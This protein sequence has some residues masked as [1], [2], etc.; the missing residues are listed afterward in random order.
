VGPGA[1]YINPSILLEAP[2]GINW[3]T[4]PS[5]RPTPDQQYA[6]QYNIC[7]RATGM[8]DAYCNQPLRATIDTEEFTGPGDFR[9]QNQP[10]G[11]TRILCSRGPVVS[12]ISGQVS[13]AASFPRSWSPIA[14]D[15]FE[16]EVP[17]IGV[18]G[19]T[20]PGDSAAGGQAVLLAPGWVN[21]AFG[22][23]SSRIQ[24]T[25]QSGWPHGSLTLAATA[26]SSSLAVDDITGWLG[27]VGTVFGGAQQEAVQVTAVTPAVTGAISGPGTLTLAAALSFNHQIGDIVSALPSAVQQA[28]ILYATAQALVRGA[29][30]TAVQSLGGGTNS[31]GPLGATDLEVAAGKLVHAY[32]RRI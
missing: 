15:Q 25:Y 3:G 27:A 11:V 8:I 9:V 26:G 18:Y 20:A 30:S 31:G 29:T 6:A 4:L 1:P 5:L 2:T 17:L 7:V 12:V 23:L 16:P 14:A 28:A 22:R 32:K 10:T 19:T 24:V 21:W 13:S